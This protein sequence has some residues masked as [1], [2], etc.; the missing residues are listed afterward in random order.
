MK[1]T[2]TSPH[3]QVSLDHGVMCMSVVDL[4]LLYG[5][6]GGV[7]R[8]MI[9]QPYTQCIS[10]LKLRVTGLISRSLAT[11]CTPCWTA[12]CNAPHNSYI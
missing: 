9:V 4:P 2:Y 5:E 6:G 10:A 8:I 12:W 7:R 3:S 1:K 11:D